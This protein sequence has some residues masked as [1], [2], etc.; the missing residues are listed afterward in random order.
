MQKPIQINVLGRMRVTHAG[1]DA[2]IVSSRK[3]R[4]LLAYLV[5]TG[6]PHHR[7]H[8]CDLFF[9]NTH[10][11][12]GALRWSLSKLRTLLNWGKTPRLIARQDR[13]EVDMTDICLDID[14]VRK[15]H[16]HPNPSTDNLRRATKLL[17]QKP[18][19]DL[20]LQRSEE[21]Q[22]WLLSEREELQELR[23]GI[24]QKLAWSKDISDPESLKWLRLWCSLDPF[25][26][27]APFAL[28]RKLSLLNRKDEAKEIASR[29]RALMGPEARE[30]TKSPAPSEEN[31]D[32]FR[33]RQSIGFCRASDGVKIAYAR[34]GSGPPLV[35]TANWL[36]HLELDW[37]S[38]IW[39]RTFQALA[40]RH[41]FIRYDERGNGLSDWDAP[42]ISF[43]SFVDDL[44]TLVDSQAIGRFP[45]LGMSQG[46]AVSIEYAV[47][48][49]DRVSALILIGGY[50][51][52]WRIGMSQEERER[53]E[54]VLTLTRL[55]WGTSNAAY[56]HIF[57]QTFMPD[58][59]PDT[60]A[61]FDDFQRQTTSAANA[62]RFQEAFG[63][64][65]V[66][67]LLSQVKAPTLVLH[68]TGDQRIP[69]EHGREL[70]AGIP[71]AR[72]VP[73]ESRSHII[74]SDEPAWQV[75]MDEIEQFLHEYG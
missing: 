9:D 43:P 60:L 63:D 75:C 6:Q 2:P 12:R 55:G 15:T 73:L 72:F 52:G 25:S 53:R 39:S 28:W 62:V 30:W 20:D 14:F 10:D 59:D 18:L 68:A 70:A 65:D 33:L 11:P 51:A 42:D 16:E 23:A 13:V 24:F 67:H 37:Q 69:V 58:A 5:M 21:Y 38:P 49:P 56:R 27:D 40:A 8:L 54:A 47:R 22:L 41:T 46:C 50:A 57:S 61:W 44:E 71:N 3:T 74:L 7:E 64:I 19:A 26:H 36:N 29:Y 1:E 31:G 32:L 48:H 17:L 35:K 66:R 4:A 34:V 45:L